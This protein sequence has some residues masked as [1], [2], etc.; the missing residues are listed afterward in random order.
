MQDNRVHVEN[1]RIHREHLDQQTIYTILQASVDAEPD[2]RELSNA[3]QSRISIKQGDHSTE[4]G[5]VCNSLSMAQEYTQTKAQ[6][7]Y[8]AN[9]QHSFG[10]GDMEPYKESQRYWL[11]DT[12]P[13]VETIFGFVEPY[14]DPMG[15]RAEF[16]GV[17]GLVNQRETGLLESLIAN[18][19]RFIAR[20]PWVHATE[21]EP[22]GPF[23][24]PSM[25]GRR[26]YSLHGEIR[27]RM[28]EFLPLL[29]EIQPLHTAAL[30]CS[31]VS[32]SQM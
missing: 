22:Y 26:F 17:V 14:R 6:A 32:I 30:W 7:D 31:R 29:K 28:C 9:L 12:S 18:S 13:S 20:L 4:L 11:Q 3:G 21:K 2:A 5:Q 23:E 16:E 10:T 24:S 1:T 8:L 19:R 15:M 27:S 25:D